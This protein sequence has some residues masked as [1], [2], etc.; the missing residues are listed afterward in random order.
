MIKIEIIQA[1]HYVIQEKLR[2]IIIIKKIICKVLSK[3]KKL[4]LVLTIFTSITKTNKK[5]KMVLKKI[6]YIYYPLHFYKN[7]KNKMQIL[8][9]FKSK[10]NAIMTAFTSKLG[11]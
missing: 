8:I 6:L 2:I 9:D 7:K 10:I 5:I 4:L 11:F 3:T 1:R